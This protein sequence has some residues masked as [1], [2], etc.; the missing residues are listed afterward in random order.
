MAKEKEVTFSDSLDLDMMVT[1]KGIKGIFLLA[2]N[3]ANS[4]VRVQPLFQEGKFKMVKISN[5]KF[6][7]NITVPSTKKQPYKVGQLLDNMFKQAEGKIYTKKLNKTN[8]KK[9]APS[10]DN[11]Y[12]DYQV[13]RLVYVYN[14]IIENIESTYDVHMAEELITNK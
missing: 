2:G 8:I 12:K 6:V 1:V 13:E 14:Y 4:W 7:A 11:D 10:I 9:F 5:L 3:P